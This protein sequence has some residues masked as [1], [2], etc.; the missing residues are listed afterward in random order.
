M[1]QLAVAEETIAKQLLE[2][3]GLRS[4]QSNSDG[5][6]GELVEELHHSQNQLEEEKSAHTGSISSLKQQLSNLE[7][8][9]D[10]QTEQCL[11][12]EEEKARAEEDLI[13]L[14]QQLMSEKKLN[15][16]R[17]KSLM[18]KLESLG[19]SHSDLGAKSEAQLKEMQTKLSN[20]YKTVKEFQ[21]KSAVL[22]VQHAAAVKQETAVAK[23][24]ITVERDRSYSPDQSD[25]GGLKDS[26]R[27]LEADYTQLSQLNNQLQQDKVEMCMNKERLQTEIDDLQNQLSALEKELSD[28]SEVYMNEISRIK[29]DTEKEKEQTSERTAAQLAELH[30]SLMK[31]MDNSTERYEL[32]LK[33]LKQELKDG[34][35]REKKLQDELAE[36]GVQCR[37]LVV[38]V[39]DLNESEVNWQGRVADLEYSQSQHLSEISELKEVIQRYQ[40]N[41]HACK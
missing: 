10:S 2:I 28:Q 37:K 19:K 16:T 14:E 7:V 31:Q 11:K 34:E 8:Y 29:E 41:Y 38:K 4:S 20:A 25:N 22:K 30:A 24:V 9:I 21:E 3:T 17:V 39:A 18:Q 1:S 40:V 5:K 15:E 23:E 13:T 12:L 36:S 32:K 33:T 26:L 6:M 27:K 35:D